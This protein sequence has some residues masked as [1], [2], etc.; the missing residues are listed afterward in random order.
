MSEA[1]KQRRLAYKKKRQKWIFIQIIAIFILAAV[2]LT[3][4][5][6]FS[7]LSKTYYARYTES[8]SADYIVNL[9]NNEFY[10]DNS[11]A[12]GQGYVSEII[13]SID[14][15]F[16]YSMLIDASGV[17][18]DYL[19]YIDARVE[20]TDKKTDKVLYSPTY[21][22]K[23]EKKGTSKDGVSISE[24]QNVD[25][26]AYNAIAEKF[27]DTYKL[28]NV[29]SRLVITMHVK[30]NGSSKEFT[31]KTYNEYST[32][33]ITPLCERTVAIET[34]ASAPNGETNL[35]PCHRDLDP[36]VFK[37]LAVIFAALALA[38]IA[39][40]FVFVR[41]TRNEDID[42]ELKVKRLLRAYRSYIQIITNE[43][44]SEGYQILTLSGFNEMLGIR[45]T[46]QSPI[47]MHE[48]EDKTRSLFFIPTST[49]ILYV[50]EIK[51]DD[52]DELYSNPAF[53][54]DAENEEISEIPSEKIDF[55]NGAF[56]VS[57]RLKKSFTAKLII[58]KASVKEYYTELKNEL[59]S[60]KKVKSRISWNY[61]AY[62]KGRAQLAKMV[63]RGKTLVLYLA[64]NPADFA[65]SKYHHSDSSEMSRYV[66]VPF[67]LKVRSARALKYAK[68]LIG[69]L[70]ANNGIEKND[71]YV[72]VDYGMPFKTKDTLIAEG[73][74]KETKK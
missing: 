6:L 51:T 15:S 21:M 33:V 65:E 4:A 47:L 31:G 71:G 23:P 58:S 28:G 66:A 50:Y 3:M 74:I 64:L 13:N 59:L 24:S 14:A 55:S 53:D 11:L 40:V 52:Y 27:I 54:Y 48:N 61:E 67:T 39:F 45:D 19:S 5:I 37:I 32:S 17:T 62:S 1:D 60:Y 26:Q 41:I 9:K 73:L 12:G 46:I 38:A 18:Y 56:S 8:G 20:I 70:M 69:T 35:L 57:S 72:F 2:A 16:K 63:I 30:V 29:E 68:E 25:Y 7:S 49:K 22:L 43:F 10:E 42:Y 36:A 34:S 44:D